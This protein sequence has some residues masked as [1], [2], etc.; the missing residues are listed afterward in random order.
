ML[1]L[2][3]C[4]TCHGR[5]YLTTVHEVDVTCLGEVTSVHLSLGAATSTCYT[6]AGD[7]IYWGRDDG[8]FVRP[9]K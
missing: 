7:S 8:I 3:K 9:Y 1:R 5:G 4:R 2:F 6:C